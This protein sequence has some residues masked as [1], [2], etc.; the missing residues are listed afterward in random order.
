[1][2][3]LALTLF[4]AAVAGLA[5]AEDGALAFADGLARRGMVRQAARE[6]EAILK[7]GPND[8][9]AF[10]LAGCYEKLGWD[11][12]A[13]ALY[14]DLAGRLT[15][16]RQAA[17][18][19]RLAVSLLYQGGQ[20]DEALT[21]LRAVADGP[22]TDETRQA[23][24]LNLGRC[25]AKLGRADEARAALAELAQGQGLFAAQA[26]AAQ[27]DLLL[28]EGKGQ[29]AWQRYRE[30][31]AWA[32]QESRATLAAEAFGRLAQAAAQAPADAQT[33]AYARAAALAQE[34]GKAPLGRAGLLPQA[35]YAAYRAKRPDEAKAWLDAEKALRPSAKPD[36]LFFEGLIA[37][38]L[39]DSQGALTAY[40]RVLAEFPDAKEAA[41]AAQAML[42]RRARDGEPDAFL[43]AW[44]R[45]SAK[46]SPEARLAL[47]PARLEAAARAKDLPQ[48]R[49]AAA[50]L[51]DNAPA[52]QAADAGYRLGLLEQQ[53]GDA[54]QAAET[55]LRT[56]ERWPDA[57][58][59][60]YA[61]YAAAYAFDQAKQPDRVERALALA[62]GSGDA[63]VAAEALLFR[64][65]N[66]LSE[67]DT[68]A[69]AAALDEFLARFPQGQGLA[70]AAYWRALLFFNAQDFQAAEALFAK[71]L[72]PTGAQGPKPLDHARRTDAAMRRA[73]ALHALGR[74]DEAAALLQPIVA[75]KDAQALAPEYLAWLAD[76]RAGRKEWP[77]A[78]AAARALAAR[79]GANRAWGNL[80][81]AQAAEAQGQKATATAAYQAV[82]DDGEDSPHAAEAACGLG[83]LRAA[84]GET[85]AARDAFALA[86]RRADVNDPSGLRVA[87]QAHAGLAAAHAALGERD[88]AL[89]ENLFL[90]TCF[91][92]RALVPAAFRAAIAEL[93]AQGRADEA[94]TLRDEFAQRFPGEDTP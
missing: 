92:D 93:E 28:A 30:A 82:L 13:R 53:A 91:D 76:F 29:E 89:R 60:G 88:K 26:K 65:R 74:D 57:P 87:A 85:A 24:L 78:E 46:L 69:A 45:V 17:A 62:L 84:A 33:E 52:A 23:A 67:R 47:E 44:A 14:R 5:A 19:L 73:Q 83:R 72:A 75:L 68:A 66:A 38:A 49:A 21:L 70:E 51:M 22:A 86:A 27:A 2:N 15:G 3:R 58:T 7:D 55:W 64:A 8:E 56:A 39:G 12:K 36:R 71:A 20:P 4:A 31:I 41:P 59:A 11:D 48:A 16:K 94:R 18:R 81:L 34:A 43:K 90:I 50:W 61:A 54:A 42:A 35:A 77:E 25:L 10:A 40:E 37:E 80:R 1:M 63:A 9:A 79:G 6:Y 32:P